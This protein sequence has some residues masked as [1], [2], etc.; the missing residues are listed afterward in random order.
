MPYTLINIFLLIAT[1][2][3]LK[4]RKVLVNYKVT[5]VIVSVGINFIVELVIYLL[6]RFN[7][8]GGD[9]G[10]LYGFSLPI[11][12][13]AYA[14]LYA[15]LLKKGN[16][17]LFIKSLVYIV[18]LTSVVL[19]IYN[20]PKLMFPRTLYTICCSIVLILSLSFFIRLFI[21]DYF[22]TN[23]L[24]QFFF[25]LSSGLMVCYLGGFMFLSNMSFLFERFTD[26]FNDLKFVNFIINIF[27]Y[28]CICTGVICLK[29]WPDSQIQ[30]L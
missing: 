13:A 9:W 26:I 12:F 28:A 19:F 2:F 29:K 7:V 1:L 30:S 24:K 21:A 10:W 16:L 18:P 5:V 22:Q 8:K 11:E 14:V 20:Y 23:P 3:L 15:R 4:N 17:W 25:W 27:L 6:I